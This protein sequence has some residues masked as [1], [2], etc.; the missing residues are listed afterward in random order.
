M[1][2]LSPKDITTKPQTSSWNCCSASPWPQSSTDFSFM[3]ALPM[4]SS[5]SHTSLSSGMLG[6]EKIPSDARTEEQDSPLP[7][8]SKPFSHFS[9][10]KS[11]LLNPFT[12]IQRGKSHPQKI[13]TLL[14]AIEKTMALSLA[15]FL[16]WRTLP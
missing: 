8:P 4:G 5:I 14:K 12:W 3:G 10:L 9:P 16:F 13:I 11:C 1:P 6:T 15:V 7:K 2:E